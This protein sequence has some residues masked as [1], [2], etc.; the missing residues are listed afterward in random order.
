MGG[1]YLFLNLE[2]N[3]SL[4]LQLSLSLNLNLNLSLFHGLFVIWCLEFGF[5]FS[6]ETAAPAGCFGFQA[7][8]E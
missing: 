5:S 1:I 8:P 4:N 3:L 2:L 6:P 7:R